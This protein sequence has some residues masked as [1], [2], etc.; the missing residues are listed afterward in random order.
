MTTRGREIGHND[1]MKMKF[2]G[3]IL[4]WLASASLTCAGTNDIT[5]LV[6]KGLFEEEANH[7]LD[8][9]IDYYKEAIG[10]FDKDRQLTATAI[11]RLGECYRLQGRTDEANDQYQRI[12]REFPDQAQ[13]VDLSKSHLVNVTLHGGPGPARPTFSRDL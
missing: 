5:S 4:T 10:N 8:A 12:I 6:Q 7:H 11:F 2:A 9:A 1:I 3:I 13:L